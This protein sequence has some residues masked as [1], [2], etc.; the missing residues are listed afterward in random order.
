MTRS[1]VSRAEILTLLGDLSDEAVVSIMES[2]ATLED[3]ET[4]LQWA[5]SEDDVMGKSGHTLSGPAAAVYDILL[6]ESDTNGDRLR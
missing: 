5:A 2:G 3:I 1:P 6:A 4:A